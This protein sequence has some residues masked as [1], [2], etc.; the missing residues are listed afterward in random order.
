MDF[1][2]NLIKGIHHLLRK[3][4]QYFIYN[5]RVLELHYHHHHPE[6]HL[7]SDRGGEW[8]GC[9]VDY[10]RPCSG[11]FNNPVKVGNPFS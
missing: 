8:V 1:L 7:W 3:Y 5:F 4:I 6:A 2:E 11:N 10:H 9:S